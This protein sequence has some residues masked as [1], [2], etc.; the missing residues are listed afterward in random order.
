MTSTGPHAADTMFHAR[1]AADLRRR[2]LPLSRPGA[3]PA[4]DA[5]FRRGRQHHARPADRPHLARSRHRLRHR[6]PRHRRSRRDD[7]RDPRLRRELRGARGAPRREPCAGPAAAAARGDRA[8][9]AHRVAGRSARTSCSTS[10]CSTGSRASR[11]PRRRSGSMRSGPG[12]GG[13]TRALLRAGARGDRGRARPALPSRR[14]PSWR[15]GVPGRLRVIEGDALADRR[16]G[17][18]RARRPCRRQPALQC[19]HR[20]AR[21]L[22]RR[23]GLAA[24]VGLADPDVPAGGG[25]ADRRRRPAAPPT[26]ASPCSPSGAA[27][28]GSR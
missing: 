26:A 4:E 21:P 13:L 27:T 17:R 5:P 8:P 7:R 28:R 11:A 3:D 23:R 1:T 9:R 12:P 2:A 20:P 18:G 19:R 15:S 16:G 24:L 14:S 25:R 6:R 10:N 22:A